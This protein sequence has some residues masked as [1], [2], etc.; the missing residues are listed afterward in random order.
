MKI[1]IITPCRNSE[2]T[3]ERT[4]K[5]VLRDTRD[6]DLEYILVDGLSTDNTMSIITSYMKKY[7]SIIK[8]ISEKDNSMTEAL[9]KGIRLATGDIIASINADDEYLPMVLPMIEKA[10]RK[11]NAD[12]ILTNTYD[13][14]EESGIIHSKS[15]PWFF[16]PFVYS[17][18]ECPFPEC[19]I[20]FKSECFK[21]FGLFDEKYKYTQDFELY[22]RMYYG[23][24]K[25]SY[26]DVDGSL[27][28]RSSTNYSSTISGKMKDEV[29][30]YF[31]YKGIL[32]I[33]YLS[34]ASKAIKAVLHLRRYYLRNYRLDQLK[35]RYKNEQI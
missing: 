18:T 5:S 32:N 8:A 26:V 29:M 27:F 25:F 24:C 15:T 4:I 3:I 13:V 2:K 19:A 12:I 23:G 33:F 11:K 22:L 16:S 20:F 6:I 35:A 1:S 9:N 31:K 30:K 17:F 28:Y 34:R 21:K 14:I 7:P 10:F